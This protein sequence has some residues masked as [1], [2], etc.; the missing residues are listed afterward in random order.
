MNILNGMSEKIWK[1]IFL[2]QQ[3]IINDILD[4]LNLKFDFLFLDT[5]PYTPGEL[6]NIIEAVPF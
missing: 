6:I 4:K 3:L 2:N 5:V 1:N